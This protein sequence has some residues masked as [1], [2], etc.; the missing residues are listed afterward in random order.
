MMIFG[1]S[2]RK[3]QKKNKYLMIKILEK[4]N[5]EINFKILNNFNNNN[6]FN[7]NN[8]FNKLFVFIL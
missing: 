1:I 5:L 7:N 6:H 2:Q 4:F 3:S 8:Q